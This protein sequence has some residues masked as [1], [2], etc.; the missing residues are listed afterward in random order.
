M[1]VTVDASVFVAAA[2]TE[3]AHYAA[4]RQFLRQVRAQDADLICPILVLPECAAAIARPTGDAALGEELV[5]LIAGVP[6]L[7][8]ISLDLPLAYRAVQIATQHRLRGADSV[9]VAVAEAFNATLI[10]WDAEMIERGSGIV[11]TVTPSQWMDQPGIADSASS[12]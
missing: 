12:A 7:R 6:G 5:A 3:E 10:T 4:S 1:N 11:P 8:L 9:Y 2:R